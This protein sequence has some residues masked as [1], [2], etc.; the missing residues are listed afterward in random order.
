MITTN[1]IIIDSIPYGK[2]IKERKQI[3]LGQNRTETLMLNMIV[4]S[5]TGHVA[6]T[7]TYTSSFTTC[8]VF[9]L[10]SPSTSSGLCYFPRV[11]T[12]LYS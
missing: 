12:H 8:S 4:V 11:L 1:I 9:P 5:A 6:L 7:G 2:E 10:P 3:Y